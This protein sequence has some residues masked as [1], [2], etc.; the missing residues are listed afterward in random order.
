MAAPSVYAAINAVTAELAGSGIPKNRFNEVDEYRYRSIDDVLIRLA[1]LLAKHRLCVL[2]RVTKRHVIERQGEEQ[3]L[4]DV[5]LRVAF[6]LVSADDGSSHLVE[7]YGEALDAGDKGTAKAM[8]AAYKSA[9]IQAF[10]IPV[11]DLE[12]PDST[13]HRLAAKTHVAEPVQGWEQWARDIQDIVAVCESEAAIDTVQDRNRDLLKAISRERHQ[14]YEE[15]GECFT[16]RRQALRSR[17]KRLPTKSKKARAA[18]RSKLA[19][20]ADV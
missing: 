17:A 11:G 10:C 2:P 5:T 16:K 9:M 7:A 4:V 8:S 20:R 12:D 14:I 18:A 13:S 15:L 6:S 3:L 1:P 19:E